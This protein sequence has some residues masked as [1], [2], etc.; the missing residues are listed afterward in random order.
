M[1]PVRLL[2]IL[3]VMATLLVD[4]VV[5]SWVVATQPMVPADWPPPAVV[6]L[7][8]LSLAQ[9]G[10]VAVWTGFGGRSL[11]W[12]ILGLVLTIGLWSRLVAWTLGSPGYVHWT[13][14]LTTQSVA[15]LVP[16]WAARLRGVRLARAD[17]AR[18]SLATASGPGPLQFSLRYLLSWITVLAVILGL[19]Q[20]AVGFEE[21]AVVPLSELWTIGL[22]PLSHGGLVLAAFWVVAGKKRLWGRALVAIAATA[23]TIA[24]NHLWAGIEELWPYTGLCVLQMLWVVASLSVFRVAGYRLV[25]RGRAGRDDQ[26]GSADTA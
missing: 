19:V 17:S 15:I 2:V 20:Y 14:L 12:R 26:A 5:V 13:R 25:R 18:L 11:P 9:V 16:L 4:L 23:A 24:A 1:R 22:F 3:L 10:L 8:A 6:A 21:L 7:F